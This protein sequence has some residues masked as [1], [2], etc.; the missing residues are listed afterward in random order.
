MT[1]DTAAL[2]VGD[3]ETQYVPPSDLITN[4]LISH[5]AGFGIDAIWQAVLHN[6]PDLTSSNLFQDNAGCAQTF[7]ALTPPGTCPAHG[8]TA[9]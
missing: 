1:E 3:F 5:S 2:I 6:D 8:C 4:S 7:N 9:N